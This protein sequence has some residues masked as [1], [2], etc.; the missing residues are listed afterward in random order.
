MP[1]RAKATNATFMSSKEIKEIEIWPREDGGY[2][3]LKRLLCLLRRYFV[4]YSSS[5]LAKQSLHSAFV[6]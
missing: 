2:K 3:R 1:K 4:R 5:R 6:A